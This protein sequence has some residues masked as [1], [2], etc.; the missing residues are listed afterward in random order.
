MLKQA[1]SSPDIENYLCYLL[2]SRDAAS[3]LQSSPESLH[4]SR[5]AS[6]IMLKND[7]KARY[8]TVPEPSRTYIRAHITE[9]LSDPNAQI[10]NFSGNVI[11][12]LV[13]QGGILGWRNLLTDLVSMIRNDDGHSSPQASEGAMGALLKVC[14]DN[15]KALS[16][17]YENQRPSDYL[18]PNLLELTSSQH[19][20]IRA[21]AVTTLNV[22][23]EAR[24]EALI[25]NMDDFLNRIFELATDTNQDVKKRICRTLVRV[26]ELAPEKIIPHLQPLTTYMLE[27]Q[28]N[29]DDPEL[30]LE[31]AE[32][33]L[34]ASEDKNIQEHLAPYLHSIVPVLL[35]CMIYSEDDVLRLEE[36]AEA[37]KAEAQDRQ[38]D[39]KPSFATKKPNAAYQP[40]NDDS[41][42]E[43]EIEDDGDFYGGDD[44][45]EQWNLRKCSAASL[46]VLATVYQKE[47]FDFTQ[48]WLMH[49]LVHKEWPHREAGV[50]TIGAIAEGCMETIHPHLPEII[51][52]LVSLLDDA[53]PVVRKISCWSVAR[54]SIWAAG[55]DESG[56]EQFFLPIM[57]GLL[58]RMLDDNKRVQEAAASAF[59]NLQEQAQADMGRPEYLE[60]IVGQYTKC[61]AIY[62]ERNM[63]ILLDGVATLASTIATYRHALPNPDLIDGLMPALMDRLKKVPDSSS[64]IFP[65]LEAFTCMT[66]ALKSSFTPYAASTYTRCLKM[67]FHDLEDTAA[68]AQSEDLEPPDKDFLITSLDLISG[69]VTALDPAET[70]KLIKSTQPHLLDLLPL[71]L[72]D[73]NSDAQQSAFAL[74]GDCAIWIFEEL[75]PYIERVMPV[76]VMRLDRSRLSKD[77]AARGYPVMNNASWSCGEMAMRAQHGELLPW[78][79]ELLQR[80]FDILTGINN[81]TLRE[82]AAIALGRVSGMAPDRVAP[83]LEHVAAHFLSTLRTV[84]SEEWASAIRGFSEAAQQNPQALESS[85]AEYLA[86]VANAGQPDKTVGEVSRLVKICCQLQRELTDE[87]FLDAIGHRDVQTASELL[88][89]SWASGWPD[90]A[91]VGTIVSGLS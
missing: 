75:Q 44:P 63:P 5:C 14:E 21:N 52:Y 57:D 51:P 55:L 18:V 37:D 27:Q 66:N 84:T 73:T 88:I 68:A 28:Q 78:T 34:A 69:I 82:N 45:E 1:R 74:L 77:A 12:E 20:K 29:D 7:I 11:T 30:A 90:S 9:G 40:A 31:A 10:R 3:R 42:E 39:I 4:T 16:K 23:L 60:V 19:P 79:D 56:K 62:K 67:I 49:N 91:S 46:D 24:A 8:P 48:P 25:N 2:S 33:W 76:V 72:Q 41:S 43:G 58:K 65:L 71:C 50:L 15:K 26:L 53:E 13:R 32:F 61:F 47:V 64:E 22:F 70:R 81:S 85:F 89:I 80:L 83:H 17:H 35:E 6:G 38:Q 86:V 36:E 87:T 54:Y 59:L